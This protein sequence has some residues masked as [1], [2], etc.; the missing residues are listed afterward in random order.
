[1]VVSLI[2]RQQ[3]KPGDFTIRESGA[4]QM[5]DT[6]RKAMLVAWQQRKQEQITH[7]FL[8][9]KT[10]VGLLLHLQARLMARYL[11]NDLDAYPPFVWK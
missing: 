7:P 9:E 11:R 3:V 4:V 6:S 8:N 1:M 2:N 5:N 10:T